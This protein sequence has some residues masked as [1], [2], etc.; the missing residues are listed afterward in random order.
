MGMTRL[1]RLTAA[2]AR[3]TAVIFPRNVS[4]GAPRQVLK[5]D[6]P[7]AAS[8]DVREPNSEAR[9][10]SGVGRAWRAWHV[11][12]AVEPRDGGRLAFVLR[13]DLLACW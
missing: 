12:A 2:T 11:R 6:V 9:G 8:A 7:R 10:H 5:A 1:S 13:D 4:A 3:L